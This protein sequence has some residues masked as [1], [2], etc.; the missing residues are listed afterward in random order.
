MFNIEHILRNQIE[1]QLLMQWQVL[2]LICTYRHICKPLPHKI[3]W[4]KKTAL[5]SAIAFKIL[6]H[7]GV[8]ADFFFTETQQHFCYKETFIRL[9]GRETL[10]GTRFG[11][12][13]APFTRIEDDNQ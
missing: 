5:L 12:L 9:G 4:Q 2:F 8:V 10:P 7:N 13:S 11:D 3:S 1:I 6:F